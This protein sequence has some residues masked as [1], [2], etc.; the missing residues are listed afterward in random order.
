MRESSSNSSVFESISPTEDPAY[1]DDLARTFLDGKSMADKFERLEMMILLV[2]LKAS[3]GNKA[4][5]ARMLGL[6]RTTLIQKC[7]KHQI[8]NARYETVYAQ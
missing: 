2:A 5:A 7:K 3:E 1:L 8:S 6:K 4:S